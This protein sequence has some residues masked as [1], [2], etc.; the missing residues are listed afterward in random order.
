M[1][2]TF[3]VSALHFGVGKQTE[4]VFVPLLLQEMVFNVEIKRFLFYLD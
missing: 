1:M 3:R 2:V 4:V